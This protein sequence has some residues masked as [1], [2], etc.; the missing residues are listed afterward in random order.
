MVEAS[1]TSIH[2]ASNSTLLMVLKPAKPPENFLLIIL[3]DH[4][5]A[6]L[7]CDS[8]LSKALASKLTFQ[9]THLSRKPRVQQMGDALNIFNPQSLV[10]ENMCRQPH[11]HS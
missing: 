11:M 4:L 9:Q 5:S 6:R 2:K 3:V 10:I 1:L 8:R 7:F